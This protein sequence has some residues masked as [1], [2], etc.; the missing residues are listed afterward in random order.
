MSR[1]IAT[2]L[3]L[4]IA[5]TVF[6]GGVVPAAAQELELRLGPDGVRPVIRDP[7]AHERDRQRGCSSREARA[8]ARDEGLRQAE[9]IRE[10]PRRITVE[11]VNRRGRIERVTFANVRGCPTI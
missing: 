6:T 5:A 1:L 11:G 8:A 10:T 4:A 2:S 7:R 3:V 9:I